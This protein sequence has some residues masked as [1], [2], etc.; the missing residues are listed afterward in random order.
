M[1]L[2]V[3]IQCLWG[4]TPLDFVDLMD[5]AGATYSKMKENIIWATG[6][7]VACCP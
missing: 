7:N 1:Q 6:Y 5:L 3:L 2:R 4:A